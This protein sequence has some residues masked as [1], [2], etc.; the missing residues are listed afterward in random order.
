F[1]PLLLPPRHDFWR[2]PEEPLPCE[3]GDFERAIPRAGLVVRSHS[4]AVEVLNN[5][6]GITVGN[7]KFGAWKWGKLSF[8][9]GIGGD[10]P[11]AESR[12]PADAALTA[13]FGDGSICGRQQSQPVAVTPVHCAS[14]YGLGDRFSQNHVSVETRLWWRAGWQLHWHHIE[15]HQASRLR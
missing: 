6:H 10:I 7:L 14:A 2:S 5:A 11:P 1:A 15:A 13:E 12:S 3:S 9:S 4:G 8:R